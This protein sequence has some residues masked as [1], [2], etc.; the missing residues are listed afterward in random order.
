MRF[1]EKMMGGDGASPLGPGEGE[2]LAEATRMI[3]GL[4]HLC[5]EERLW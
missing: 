4:E 3:M 5:Y 1:I 2:V